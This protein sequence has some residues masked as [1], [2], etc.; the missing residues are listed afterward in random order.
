MIFMPEDGRMRRRRGIINAVAARYSA[1]IDPDLLDALM[2]TRK[3]PLEAVSEAIG[4]LREG[5]IVL[6]L[7]HFEVER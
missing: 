4:N 2:A 1:L 3:D 7:G 5:Q 6:T